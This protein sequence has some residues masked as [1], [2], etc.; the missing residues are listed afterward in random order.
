VVSVRQSICAT[1]ADPQVLLRSL[2]DGDASA[3]LRQTH[4]NWVVLT[5]DRAYKLPRPV[6]YDFVDQSSPAARRAACEE[7]VALNADLAPG[8][9]LG[10]HGVVPDGDGYALG[11]ADDPDAIDH[12]VAMARYDE[13]RTLAALHRSGHLLATTGGAVGA[14]LARFHRNAARHPEPLDHRAIIDRNTEALLPLVSGL[15]P[16]RELLALQRFSDAFLLGW[17][18]VLAARARAGLVVDGHGDVRAEHVLLEERGV[19]IVDRL[20]IEALRQVDVADELAFLLADLELLGAGGLGPAILDGY[21]AAGGQRPPD[22]LLGFFGAYRAMVRAKVALLRDPDGPR[23]AHEVRMLLRQARR[24][25]WRARGPLTLLVCGPP[26]SGKSTLASALSRASG[27]RVLASDEVRATV[28]RDYSPAGRRSVYS[29]LGRLATSERAVI[30]DATFGDPELQDAFAAAFTDARDQTVLAVECV[31][32]LLTRE[33]RAEIRAL[34][35][36]SASD[37]GPD[38]T[39]RLA[40]TYTPPDALAV[41]DRLAIDTTVP[42]DLQVDQVESWLD[43]QLTKREI[44]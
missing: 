23:T 13:S 26:A 9:V 43:T 6:H 34:R 21:A 3:V 19:R 16:A 42:I 14:V 11:D 8:L 7:Q 33:A 5:G 29:E 39:R 41:T 36:A 10:V 15:V 4:C 28:G 31:A 27:L 17:E 44:A 24:M 37:A 25:A 1:G 12:V 30:V 2:G 35:G 40:E 38:V 20:E 18:D 32:P 22:R